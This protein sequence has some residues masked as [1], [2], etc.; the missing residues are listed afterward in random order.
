MSNGNN[1]FVIKLLALLDKQKSKS[2][3]NSDINNLEQTIRKIK[4]VA[5]CQ[6]EIE[7]IVIQYWKT[8]AAN[9]TICEVFKEWNDRRLELKK[10]SNASI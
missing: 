1:E 3:I 5:P 6:K 9:P 4:I 8:E 2:Q 10:I 7:D